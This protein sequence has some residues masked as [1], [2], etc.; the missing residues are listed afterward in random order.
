MI[1]D[2]CYIGDFVEGKFKGYGKLF[3]LQNLLYFNKI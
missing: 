2:Y 1:K 3:F